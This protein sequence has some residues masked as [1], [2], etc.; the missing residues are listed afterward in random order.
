LPTNPSILVFYDYE[1]GYIDEFDKDPKDVN[2]LKI[3]EL[4]FKISDV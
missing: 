1:F 4:V 3:A 2:H